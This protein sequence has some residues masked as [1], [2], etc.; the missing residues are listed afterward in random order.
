MDTQTQRKN[1]EKL[2]GG[3]PISET[4]YIEIFGNLSGFFS[5]LKTWSDEERKLVENEQ[6][7]NKRSIILSSTP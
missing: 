3:K 7:N 4:E 2:Y 5:T 6:N 1:W